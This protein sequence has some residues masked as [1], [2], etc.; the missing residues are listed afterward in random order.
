MY[1]EHFLKQMLECIHKYSREALQRFFSKQISEGIFK[2]SPPNAK[3][4]FQTFFSKQILGK[5]HKHSLS[6][7]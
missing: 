4:G 5:A 3:E 2:H 7:K 6:K 1:Y